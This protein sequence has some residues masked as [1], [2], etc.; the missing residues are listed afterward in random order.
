MRVNTGEISGESRQLGEEV[1]SDLSCIPQHRVSGSRLIFKKPTQVNGVA[2]RYAVASICGMRKQEY[3]WQILHRSAPHCWHTAGSVHRR[4]PSPTK[5]PMALL[6]IMFLKA[7]QCRSEEQDT[8]NQKIFELRLI[9]LM[10][11]SQSH[12]CAKPPRISLPEF[13]VHTT[14]LNDF[15][16]RKSTRLLCS[17]GD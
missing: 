4:V 6:T 9:W 16:V 7:S 11:K 12:F 5:S 14:A 1:P 2:T 13:E 10:L 3:L 8:K 17:L 15:L